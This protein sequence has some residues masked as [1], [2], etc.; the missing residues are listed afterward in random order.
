MRDLCASENVEPVQVG[1]GGIRVRKERERDGGMVQTIPG[2]R[3]EAR[4]GVLDES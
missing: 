3:M 2:Q 1:L 4:E